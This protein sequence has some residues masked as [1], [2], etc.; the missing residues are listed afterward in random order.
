MHFEKD[1]LGSRGKEI[2]AEKKR[3]CA[4]G[5]ALEKTW[6]I[7]FLT[8]EDDDEKYVCDEIMEV[9]PFIST[10]STKPSRRSRTAGRLPRAI[11]EKVDSIF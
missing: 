11:W 3:A 10:A 4:S 6:R 1:I 9:S 5:E 7:I 8:V 2:Q